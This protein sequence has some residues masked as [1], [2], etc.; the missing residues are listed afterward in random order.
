MDEEGLLRALAVAA[1]AVHSGEG[2]RG[3]RCHSTLSLAVIDLPF[4]RVLHCN[5]AVIAA[6]FSRND[7]NRPR[8]GEGP[9]ESARLELFA[10]IYFALDAAAVTAPSC[11]LHAT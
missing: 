10:G 11:S 9:P 2:S 8:L 7:S 3:R 5:L 1:Q 6:T 4:L